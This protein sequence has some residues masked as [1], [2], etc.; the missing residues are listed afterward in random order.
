M[1]E[2]RH[3]CLAH[4]EIDIGVEG[5]GEAP[6]AGRGDRSGLLRG[7]A[8]GAARRSSGFRRGRLVASRCRLARI[9]LAFG[10]GEARARGASR[11]T[12]LGGG[13][14]SRLAALAYRRRQ[15]LWPTSKNGLRSR[16]SSASAALTCGR[17]DLSV[18]HRLALPG[19]HVRAQSAHRSR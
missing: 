12:A 13:G 8:S 15:P 14:G 11:G 5:A 3:V 7:A 16:L 6:V 2:M 10:A 1:L 18:D 4:V 9:I 17:G 19:R